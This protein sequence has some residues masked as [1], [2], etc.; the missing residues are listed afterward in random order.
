MDLREVGEGSTDWIC[1]D[2]NVDQW[3]IRVNSVMNVWVP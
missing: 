1:L 2:K 3:K